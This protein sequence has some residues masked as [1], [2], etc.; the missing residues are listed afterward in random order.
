MS[1]YQI[2]LFFFNPVWIYKYRLFNSVIMILTAAIRKNNS[3]NR[4]FKTCFSIF[5]HDI[6]E[7]ILKQKNK[8]VKEE[9]MPLKIPI[10]TRA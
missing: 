4:I 6:R 10:N 3:L 8:P 5:R 1:H 9:N 2:G 7:E